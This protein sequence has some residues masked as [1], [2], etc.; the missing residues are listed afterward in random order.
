MCSMRCFVSELHQLSSANSPTHSP[1][2][3]IPLSLITCQHRERQGF[4]TRASEV[5][6][7]TTGLSLSLSNRNNWRRLWPEKIYLL[8]NGT[9]MEITA[10]LW[11]Q[12]YLCPSI[13]RT[14]L[15][16][17][18]EKNWVDRAVK[19]PLFSSAHFSFYLSPSV[20]EFLV[21]TFMLWQCWQKKTSVLENQ[22]WV[23]APGSEYLMPIVCVC[24]RGDRREGE[25]LVE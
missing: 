14:R 5:E 24:G 4:G 6:E 12:L 2:I 17:S 21:L 13:F 15:R 3:I 19:E 1:T 25:N 11:Y 16:L 9:Q 22:W 18:R 7:N 10:V 23:T 20:S 8:L